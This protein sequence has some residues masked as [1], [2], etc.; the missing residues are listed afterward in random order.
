M[1]LEEFYAKYTRE[2]WL[3]IV[4]F[5]FIVPYFIINGFSHGRTRLDLYTFIEQHI[6]VIP[7]TVLIYISVFFMVFVPYLFI[8]DAQ[9]FKH[10][11]WSYTVVMCF[12]YLVF[13]VFPIKAVRPEILGTS[14]FNQALGWLYS[15]DNPYNNFPSLHVALA[16]LSAKWVNLQ[17]KTWGKWMILWAILITLSTLTTKQHTL[18]DVIAGAAVGL[19]G[20]WIFYRLQ[21]EPTQT[22]GTA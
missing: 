6:P 17:D 22:T 4:L 1:K 13:L 9:R 14:F 2:I 19:L 11:A 18:A 16:F 21:H 20:Y 8:K 3:G 7:F 12:A 10:V 15:L 5:L